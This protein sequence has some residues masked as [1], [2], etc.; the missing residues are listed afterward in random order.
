MFQVEQQSIEAKIKAFCAGHGIPLAELKWVPIPFSGEWG[1]STSFF[2]TA[3]DEARSGKKV[4]VPQRAQEIAEQ[5]RGTFLRSPPTG[6]SPSKDPVSDV[7]GISHVEAVKG[8]LNL[9]FD[10]A[11]YACRVVDTVL[12]QGVASGPGRRGANA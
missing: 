3:A 2:L 8:Y 4:V 7:P 12:E 10:T 5:V 9:Y 6:G 11:E 1:I